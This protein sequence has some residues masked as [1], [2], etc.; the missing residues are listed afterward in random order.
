[1][2]SVAVDFGNF[3]AVEVVDKGSFLASVAVDEDNF[4]ASEAVDDL[5][6]SQVLEVD[7]AVN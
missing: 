3:L 1:M 4:R 2:A 7:L 6:S 5:E